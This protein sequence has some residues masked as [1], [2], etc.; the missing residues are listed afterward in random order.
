MLNKAQ[1]LPFRLLASALTIGAVAFGYQ[2]NAQALTF[3]FNFTED[4]PTIYVNR[5]NQI[6]DVWGNYIHDD[7]TVNIKV[8]VGELP[9]G[10]LGGARPGMVKVNYAD[11]VQQL[12]LDQLSDLDQSAAA[13]MPTH[14][15]STGELSIA[16][17]I[18]GTSD[19]SG[20]AHV[21]TNTKNLWIT[22][23][24]AKALGIVSGND[25][26]VDA[27]IRLNDQVSWDFDPRNGIMANR[28]DFAGTVYHELAHTLG[29]LSGV[30]VLDYNAKQNILLSDD[31]YDYVTSMDL[32]RYS[33]AVKDSGTI[34]WTVDT[35]TE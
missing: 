22:R 19:A 25:T 35:D 28:Y 33:D 21:D 27:V 15:S 9:T 4:T 24:N 7:V 1:T 18:N 14:Q 20:L 2:Q 8:E 6:G 26:T 5:I 34:D 11:V 10:Y 32:F 13:N 31:S 12:E 16:R 17:T 23:A 3:N 30:D 29:F